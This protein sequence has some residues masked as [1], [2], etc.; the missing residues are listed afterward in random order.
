M[1]KDTTKLSKAAR[2]SSLDKERELARLYY[3]QGDTQ[4]AIAERIGVSAVTVNRWVAAGRWDALRAAKIITRSELVVKMLGQINQRLEEGDWTADEMIKATA[5]IEKLDK[6]TNVVTIIEVFTA[7]NK[8]LLSRAEIDPDLTP[9]MVRW[10][11]K[12]QN[13]YISEQMSTHQVAFL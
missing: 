2:K 4:K 9:E 8:W 10:M 12:Y 7:Y 1:P 6:Q 13:L 3:M 5:A 11:N